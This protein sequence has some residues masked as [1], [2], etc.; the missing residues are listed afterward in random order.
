M[1]ESGPI[2]PQNQGTLSVVTFL[3]M[4]IAL[5][6][7]VVALREARTAGVG[8]IA[9]EM[10]DMKQEK[11]D[12]KAVDARMKALEDRIAALESRA[13]ASA[14]PETTAAAR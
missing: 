14:T 4:V 13:S 8:T 10:R 2:S 9:L 6:L 3:G 7:G 11:A 5:V 12:A 1:S